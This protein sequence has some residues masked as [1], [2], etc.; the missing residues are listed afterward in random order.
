M[1][2]VNTIRAIF[3][4][5]LLVEFRSRRAVVSMVVLGVLL[6]W[7]FRLATK[8]A[9]VDT[10]AVAAAV[11]L[12]ATFFAVIFSSE[13]IFAAEH[14][15]DCISALVASPADA[16]DI[17]LAKLLANIAM[18]GV[19]EIMFVPAVLVMFETGI[20]QRL[21]ELIG[22]LVV[23]NVGIA[24]AGTL[25]GAMIAAVKSANS[26][27]SIL[28][29]VVLC[30]VIIP[31]VSALVF[32]LGAAGSHSSIPVVDLGSAVGF[33]IAFDAIFVTVG[34]LLFGFVL[35]E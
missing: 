19:F 7:V 33:L 8:D 14:D 9:P 15:N 20:W 25:L 28:V 13:R 17:Y 31:A 4:K 35:D 29:L 27:L 18:L 24:A 32:V 1:G 26:L 6:A 34:W 30:P 22:L 12:I 21:L 23:V 10:A 11:L 16:G 3:I 2:S 5:D